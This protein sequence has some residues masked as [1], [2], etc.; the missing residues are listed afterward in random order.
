MNTLKYLYLLASLTFFVFSCKDRSGD[1]NVSKTPETSIFVST[2][3]L[4]GINSLSGNIKLNWSG[5]SPN[6]FIKSYEFA[7]DYNSCTNDVAALNALTWTK[8]SKT[9]STFLFNI[10]KGQI[11]SKVTFYVRAIDQLD[12][13]DATPACLEIPI[14]NSIP[15]IT[16]DKL[17]NAKVIYDTIHSVFTLSWKADDVDGAANLDSVFIKINDSKWVGL[18]KSINQVTFVPLN[19]SSMDSTFCKI[20]TGNDAKLF[21]KNIAG[22]RLNSSNRLMI[23]SKDISNSFSKIDSTNLFYC[24]RKISDLLYIDAFST[25]EDLNI[26]NPI[27]ND[28]FPQGVDKINLISFK[29]LLWNIT[30]KEYLKLYKKVYWNNDDSNLLELASS[31]LESYLSDGGKILISSEVNVRDNNSPLI[32]FA[33]FD[34]LSNNE[35]VQPRINTLNTITGYGTNE[36][37]KLSSSQ[38]LIN[39]YTQYPKVNADSYLKLVNKPTTNTAWLGTNIIASMTKRNNKP[40][41]IFFTIPLHRLNGNPT[42]LK[43][44]LNQILNTEFAD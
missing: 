26:L 38:T 33:P 7:I 2:I 6:G 35:N 39:V 24:K 28:L 37:Y 43:N 44:L 42:E 5:E 30:F 14:K 36:T 8:T 11:F 32:R 17:Y 19:P 29:P 27:F 13:K 10:P 25:N 31:S 15:T 12:L 23:K 9:D 21:S 4:G 1:L 22:L 41:Q 18:P 40:N 20:L 16:F 3:N 34:S